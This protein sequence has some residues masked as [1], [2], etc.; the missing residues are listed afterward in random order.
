HTL[1]VDAGQTFSLAGSLTLDTV[2]LMP[3]RSSPARLAVIGDVN[4][5][6]LNNATGSIVSGLGSGASGSIDL[7]SENRTW[8]V[9]DGAAAVDLLVDVPVSNG[10]LIKDGPGTLALSDTIYDG[11][12]TVLD[13]IL[14]L[15]NAGLS[16]TANVILTSG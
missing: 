14:S 5:Q 15:S 7:G 2:Q 6:P 16:D 4:F 8:N 9:A 3:N 12:T 13:G 10:G 1:Q 11:D